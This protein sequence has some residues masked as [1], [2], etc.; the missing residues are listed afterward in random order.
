MPGCFWASASGCCCWGAGGVV[1]DEAAGLR[2]D[3]MVDVVES[4]VDVD[5][6]LEDVEAAEEVVA[7]LPMVVSSREAY[8]FM[9]NRRRTPEADNVQL[10]LA[11]HIAHVVVDAVVHVLGLARALVHAVAARGEVEVGRRR[12]DAEVGARRAPPE[13]VGA[14]APDVQRCS[15]S[16]DLVARG[17]TDMVRQADVALA[18][19]RRLGRGVVAGRVLC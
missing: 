17:F 4:V 7:A 14:A 2:P 1:V 12:V 18:A 8:P 9:V 13:L 19:A 15:R 3:G 10:L 11:V 6:D 5:R 16:L